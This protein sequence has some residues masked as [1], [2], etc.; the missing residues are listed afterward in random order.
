MQQCNSQPERV[1]AGE[2]TL[3]A[4]DIHHGPGR[5]GSITIPNDCAEIPT[6]HQEPKMEIIDAWHVE[7]N[8]LVNGIGAVSARQ[9]DEYATAPEAPDKS[10]QCILDGETATGGNESSAVADMHNPLASIG[11]YAKRQDP[12]QW[13]CAALEPTVGTTKQASE[14][15]IDNGSQTPVERNEHVKDKLPGQ[16]HSDSENSNGHPEPNAPVEDMSELAD[17]CQVDKIRGTDATMLNHN[18][19]GERCRTGA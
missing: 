14:H 1:A 9:P 15:S 12:P 2:T 3:N 4:S 18:I 13:S 6:G 8:L 11:T 7:S 19:K 17:D 16:I 5:V 10:S